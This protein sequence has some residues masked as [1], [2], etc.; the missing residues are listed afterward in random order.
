MLDLEFQ[1]MPT[2]THV[3]PHAIHLQDEAH[4]DTETESEYPHDMVDAR[5]YRT[6]ADGGRRLGSASSR[7]SSRSSRSRE[8]SLGR[9]NRRQSTLTQDVS[10]RCEHITCI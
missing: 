10:I 1:A 6:M 9:S 8:G 3:Y 5:L 2:N 4:E 7:S